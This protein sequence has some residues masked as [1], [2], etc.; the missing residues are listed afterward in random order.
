MR[1]ID[2]A[3]RDI[4]IVRQLPNGH[5]KSAAARA[6][7]DRIDA[8]GPLEAKAYALN[9][10]VEAYYFSD[11]E[12]KAFVPFT[13]EV[14]WYDAHPEWF[15]EMDKSNLFWS[16]KW[17]VS[18]LRYYPNVPLAQLEA[19]LADMENRYAVAGYGM[20]A[21]Y[22]MKWWLA[23]HIGSPDTQA[24]F[25]QWQR[26]ARDDMSDC[27]LCSPADRC[28]YLFELGLDDEGLRVLEGVF[29]DS[30]IRQECFSEPA[31]ILAKAQFAYLRRGG[32]GDKA[33][34][35]S[36]HHRCR[37]YLGGTS[38]FGMSARDANR[39]QERAHAL[40][41][42]RGL[43]VEF[44]ARTHNPQAAMRLL[45]DNRSFLVHATPPLARLDFL[46]HV[47]AALHVMV[48]EDNLGDEP[49]ALQEPR[50][51]TLG[52]LW[53]WL[54]PEAEALAAQFDNRNDTT[55]QTDLL[56]RAW[57]ATT[58]AEPL[59]LHI[60]IAADARSD[61]PVAT[62]GAGPDA[63]AEAPAEEDPQSL[64]KQADGEFAAGR[65]TGAI[66]TYLRAANLFTSQG[67]LSD[68]GFALA[69]AGRGALILDD[70]DTATECLTRASKLLVVSNTPTQFAAPV[71]IVLA[72][73]LF[74]NRKEAEASA[75]LD[76]T[77]NTIETAMA[78]KAPE[79]EAPDLTT[80]R[81]NDLRWARTRVDE[82]RAEN[83][84]R[85]AEPGAAALAQHAGE[86][87]GQLGMIE[88]AAGAFQLAGEAWQG[89]DDEQA[90]WCLQSAVEGYQIAVRRPQKQQAVNQLVVL[91]QKLGR[92]DEATA[93]ATDL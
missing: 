25:D 88:Q 77:A 9:T 29:A 93:V 41:E 67:R 46:K 34:A 13:Q 52:E 11:E 3:N 43:C 61:A 72:E 22:Q 49:V 7:V 24:L 38:S 17:M 59:D 69:E 26:Q 40:S 4:T 60:A 21:P 8:E 76:N 71:Q 50:V 28:E 36:A 66:N 85:N 57:Q 33:S 64:L 87:Y 53:A 27:E 70:L 92:T 74:R 10:L 73:A 68:G 81:E 42:A 80:R 47:G 90:V 65:A 86:S 39:V 14:A 63:T 30:S 78:A 19:T 58:F 84:F 5:A 91:L 82:M 6:E 23:R 15:D 20:D 31:S 45:E 83:L 12:E 51:A 2:E 44:L 1:S 18:G 75:L 62:D 54:Q 16:F 79:G 56:H 35:I 37:S 55:N 89:I 48:D 32:P